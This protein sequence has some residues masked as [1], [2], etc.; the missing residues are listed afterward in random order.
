MRRERVREAGRRYQ[1]TE[2]GRRL[3]AIRQARYRART[4]GVTHQS[5]SRG[6]RNTC[7]TTLRIPPAPA[8]AIFVLFSVAELAVPA[9]D[10]PVHW[11]P[12]PRS[13]WSGWET[14]EPAQPIHRDFTGEWLNLT[15]RT[16]VLHR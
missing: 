1:A 3:H 10:P 12:R 15:A 6:F 11:T 4:S 16:C 7:A 9:G 13:E 2:R 14:A 5:A 8:L